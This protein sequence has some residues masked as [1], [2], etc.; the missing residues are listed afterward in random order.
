M[1]W[2]S[3]L[4]IFVRGVPKPSGSKSGFP[5][6]DKATGKT[7]VRMVDACKTRKPWMN[8][9]AA[10]ARCQHQGRPVKGPIKLSMA[11]YMPRPK[12]HYGTG[13]NAGV[14]KASAPREHLQKPDRTK[15]LRCCEDA[16]TGILWVDDTQVIGGPTTKEWAEIDMPPGVY[17]KVWRG[18]NHEERSEEK[19]M[20]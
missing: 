18:E 6:R 3:W 20:A 19:E 9:V 12:S 11:F 5:Y 1:N 13:R 7:R 8:A 2:Q 14:L 17:I 4:H 16:L 15:L 10:E